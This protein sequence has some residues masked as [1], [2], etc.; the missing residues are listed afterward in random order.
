VFREAVL[1]EALFDSR[2]SSLCML[3][4]FSRT[5]T[6]RR[7]LAEMDGLTATTRIRVSCLRARLLILLSQTSFVFRAKACNICDIRYV[8]SSSTGLAG[9]LIQGI[10]RKAYFCSSFSVVLMLPCS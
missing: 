1:G 7:S 3:C 9:Q 2:A 10:L 8:V 6:S 4:N 5:L